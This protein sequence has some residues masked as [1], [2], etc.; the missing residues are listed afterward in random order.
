MEDDRPKLVLLDR[1]LAERVKVLEIFTVSESVQLGGL[2]QLRQNV[3]DVVGNGLALPSASFCLV[4]YDSHVGE[5]VRLCVFEEF[6]V[7]YLTLCFIVRSIQFA[8]GSVLL[9]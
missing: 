5:V 6:K 2:A 8:D 3:F 7:K 9:L 1:A 4:L